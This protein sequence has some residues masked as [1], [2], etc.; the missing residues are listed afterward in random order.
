MGDLV[1]KIEQNLPVVLKHYLNKVEYGKLRI[2][3]CRKADN[4]INVP[5]GS[6]QWTLIYYILLQTNDTIDM[7]LTPTNQF[8]IKDYNER[9]DDATLKDLR[10]FIL[11][12]PER[13][14]REVIDYSKNNPDSPNPKFLEALEATCRRENCKPTDLYSEEELEFARSLE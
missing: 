11:R 10:P 2:T 6:I 5:Q 9:K 8:I 14:R 7:Y 1:D 13:R 4:E 12:I 3:N